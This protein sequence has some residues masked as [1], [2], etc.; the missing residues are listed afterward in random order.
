MMTN[1]ATRFI[2]GLVF[3]VICIFP[4]YAKTPTGQFLE[5]H[6]L[7]DIEATI[8]AQGDDGFNTK[9]FFPFF[10][11]VIEQENDRCFGYHATNCGH[12]IFQEIVRCT[13]EVLYGYTF[14]ENF[15]FLR[16]P[17]PDAQA[18]TS[19][20]EYL[21][22]FSRK[23]RSAEEKCRFIELFFLKP[24]ARQFG[25]VCCPGSV[26]EDM[27]DPL[28]SAL[29]RFAP[30]DPVIEKSQEEVRIL[31][32]DFLTQSAAFGALSVD[33]ALDL[34]IKDPYKDWEEELDEDS[35]EFMMDILYPFNDTEDTQQALLASLNIPL[36][37]NYYV[38]TESTIHVF[39]KASSVS[40]GEAEI[41]AKARAFLKLVG[42][43]SSLADDIYRYAEERLKLKG[44]VLLQF[45]T[46]ETAS[47]RQ[48]DDLAFVCSN[49]G[50]P[51]RTVRPS[52]LVDDLRL[53]QC[54]EADVPQLGHIVLHPQ[55]RLY[56]MPSV[57][58]NPFSGL[59]IK[60]YDLMSHKAKVRLRLYIRQKVQRA[61]K[62]PIKNSSY[63][64]YLQSI[65]GLDG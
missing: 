30:V 44:G 15:Y 63:R 1:M 65:W 55:L 43:R 48:L 8:E 59:E 19:I 52:A 33:E 4:G 10:L 54:E 38:S 24:M 62:D 26:Q 12:K 18:F 23:E 31:L 50:V 53:H 42:I 41:Q 35:H 34:W 29:L 61:H 57:V 27:I 3:S 64:S 58:L 47:E 17:D 16:A 11:S 36:F 6:S 56:M 46:K 5:T 20:Q 60:Q 51:N 28:F 25:V 22:Q 2:Y 9:K 37:G 14:T 40:L 21:R 39:A 32:K 7:R 45:F 49:F 13:L